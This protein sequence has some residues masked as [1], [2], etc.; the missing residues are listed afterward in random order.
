MLAA[1]Q[2]R[3]HPSKFV[4]IFGKGSSARGGDSGERGQ[5]FNK[6]AM[7]ETKIFNKRSL[8]MLAASQERGKNAGALRCDLATVLLRFLQCKQVVPSKDS[9]YRVFSGWAINLYM[10][11]PDNG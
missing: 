4:H 1:R 8:V 7:R 10:C 9:A 3:L 5:S 11:T 2:E 6:S